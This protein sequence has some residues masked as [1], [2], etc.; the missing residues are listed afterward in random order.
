MIGAQGGGTGEGPGPRGPV[1]WSDELT[2]VAEPTAVRCARAFVRLALAKWASA[3]LEDDASVIV[4][5][6]TTNAVTAS[7]K[8]TA[9]LAS[10]QTQTTAQTQ[11]GAANGTYAEAGPYAAPG[12]YTAVPRMPLITV[13]MLGTATGLVIEVWDTSPAA[14]TP[15]APRSDAEEWEAEGGRG[16]HLVGTLAHRWG[17]RP[18]PRGKVVWAH[19]GTAGCA[20]GAAG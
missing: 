9:A 12:T 7:E 3:T 13:R 16:L 20:Q 6:L 4:S 1:F 10:A 8:H 17:W 5:E 11:A 14:P 2:L 18:A 15:T 19:L